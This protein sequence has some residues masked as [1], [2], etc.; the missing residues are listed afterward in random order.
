LQEYD[1]AEA[2]FKQALQ[3]RPDLAGCYRNLALLY[4]QTGRTNEAAAAFEHYFLLH[5][6]DTPLLKKYAEY[7]TGAGRR[8]DVIAF[9]ERTKGT[10]PLT[11][12][13]LLARA[14]AQDNDGERALRALREVSK[15]LTPRQMIAEMHD[16]A[17]EPIARTEPFETLMY[18]LELAAVSLSTN[19]I[20]SAPAP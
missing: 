20:D 1:R 15:F 14:A 13:L 18:Q 10:D 17:F 9:L 11:T 3:L 4:Q 8:R 16:A 5:P 12:G 19:L 2:L 6:A 7:L